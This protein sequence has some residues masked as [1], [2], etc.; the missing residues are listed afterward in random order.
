MPNYWVDVVFAPDPNMA[1]V[2][3]DE[4]GFRIGKDGM[5]AISFA[6]LLANDSDA[7]RDPL[8]VTAVGNATNGSVTIDAQTG[9]VLF[10]PTA[11]YSGPAT[12]TYTVSDGR[13]GTDTANVSLTVKQEP[14]GV[15]L[16]QWTEGPT[17][18]GFT[19]PSGLE[20]GMKFTSAVN[21]SITGVRFYKMANDTGQHTGSLWSRPAS[22][23]RRLHSPMSPSAAGR[24]RPSP[25]RSR[26]RRERPTSLP[27]T[28]AGSMPRRELFRHHQ[29]QR[30][31]E[32]A[33][34]GEQRRK[35]PL[36][37]RAGYRLP[38]Q[39]AIWPP[40]IGWMSFSSGL[41]STPC[42]PPEMTTASP[43]PTAD[44]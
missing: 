37:L 14:A 31:V 2:A 27:T 23:W 35:R 41:P 26:S 16:F 44:R 38:D 5:I 15:S 19:D 10:T 25:I 22:C 8:T 33:V 43:F 9:N 36:H 1:P 18:P 17:G 28:R 32:R 34:V 40:T 29:E 4:F 12:F 30:L 3:R 39:P 24:R 13:G 6:S 21:G 11:G 42:R 7:N 20:L